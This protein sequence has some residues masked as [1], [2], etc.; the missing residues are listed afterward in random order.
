MSVKN[1]LIIF[2][3]VFLLIVGGFFYF[4]QQVYFSHGATQQEKKFEI[5][6]GE[7]VSEIAT[8]LIKEQLISGKIYFYYYIRT[9][10]LSGKIMP[11][12]HFLSGRMTI[13]EIVYELTKKNNQT[14][15]V[16]FPEGW[17]SQKMSARLIKN[18]LN[19]KE[20]LRIVNH[21]SQNIINQ[22]NFLKINPSK[23]LKGYLFPDT[24]YFKKNEQTSKIILTMLNNF[25]NK[26]TPS[27]KQDIQRQGKTLQGIITMA[28]LLEMEVKTQKDRNLVSGI[29]W[30]RIKIGMPLQSDITLT[31]A[32]GKRKAHYSLQ[33]TQVKS[34]Y[35]T[36]R[37][38]GLPPGPIGNP[39][40]S[41]IKAA[42]YP[43]TS[44]YLYFLS[45]PKTG[46]T[47]YSRTFQEHIINKSK[48][49][50]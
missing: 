44:P 32:T 24:Y 13:P 20:F 37:N 39:G 41:A 43:E 27:M 18:G 42:I 12:K 40:L 29:F 47:I 16:T 9:N 45:N 34:S 22:Y 49:G 11:G 19:G 36:Y 1:K 50:L 23:N 35:N 2:F 4:R 25:K 17:D 26:I 30:K 3:L 28:S 15:K 33:D 6:Q 14:I 10:K 7:K 21:P 8:R 5:T 46:K 38:K 48:S 31:Y